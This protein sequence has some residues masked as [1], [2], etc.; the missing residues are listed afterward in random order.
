MNGLRRFGGALCVALDARHAT[1]FA[2]PR[3][4]ARAG[5]WIAANALALR[6]LAVRPLPLSSARIYDV[7]ARSLT[8]LLAAIAAVPML[9]DLDS[10]PKHWRWMVRS[11]GIPRAEHAHAALLALGVSIAS[12]RADRA[13]PHGTIEVAQDFAGYQVR[14]TD[15]R[16]ALVA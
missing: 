3:D 12:L 2:D 14:A 4:R 5:R 13:L 10:L 9:V 7:R 1:R 16:H 6:G 15:G 8:D 11:L